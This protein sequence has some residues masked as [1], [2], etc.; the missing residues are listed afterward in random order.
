MSQPSREKIS[1]KGE[2]SFTSDAPLE[3]IRAKS[4]KLAGV[5]DP[6]TGEFAF[7]VK[8]KTFNGFNSA[9]QQE[10]FHENYMRTSMYPTLS[11]SG[12]LLDKLEEGLSGDFEVRTKGKFYINGVWSER[13][14][15]HKA[16]INN[17]KLTIE[18]DFIIKLADHNILIPKI[19]NKKIAEEIHIHLYAYQT[20]E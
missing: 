8:L 9:L 15:K 19:V 1:F 18:S 2:V 13:I 7:S 16:R 11:Y 12:K 3:V 5:I 4:D 10:H 17:H 14:L 20:A 6:A